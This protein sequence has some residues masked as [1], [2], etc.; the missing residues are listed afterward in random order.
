[1][2]GCMA[3]F[4]AFSKHICFEFKTPMFRFQNTYVS[5]SKHRCFEITGLLLRF[6][7]VYMNNRLYSPSKLGVKT[8]FPMLSRISAGDQKRPPSSSEG[9]GVT[10]P[11]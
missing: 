8:P 3:S 2:L 10:G 7:V 5:I 6:F 1:M 11:S 4:F 9:S